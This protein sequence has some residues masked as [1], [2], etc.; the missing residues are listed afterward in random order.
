MSH[1]LFF[2]LPAIAVALPLLARRYPGE[3]VLIALRTTRPALP[4]AAR[5]VQG[6]GRSD[7]WAPRGGLLMGRS[8]AV[9]P[10]PPATPA[11]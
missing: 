6:H 2:L 3:D 11:S 4:R 5:T 7:A 10:P 8:L 1:A 9:R